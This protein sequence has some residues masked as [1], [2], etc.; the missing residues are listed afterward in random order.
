MPGQQNC[1]RIYIDYST[2][3]C[4]SPRPVTAVFSPNVYINFYNATFIGSYY[5][6]HFCGFFFH[7]GLANAGSPTVL[8]NMRRIH[9]RG[10]AI[11]CGDTANNGSPNVLA[12]T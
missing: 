8:V 11:N 1:I 2:G 7:S 12:G 4:F 9:R 3:H 6:V 10:D 5:P